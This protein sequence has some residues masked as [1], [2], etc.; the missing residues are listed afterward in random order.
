MGSDLIGFERYTVAKLSQLVK[1]KEN[2]CMQS[3]TESKY[4]T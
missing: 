2:T 1:R 4:N 3:W